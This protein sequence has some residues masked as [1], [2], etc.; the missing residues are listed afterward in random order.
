MFVFLDLEGTIITDWFDALII[1]D[2]VLAEWKQALM[3][4]ESEVTFGIFS[5]AIHDQNDIQYFCAN[6]LPWIERRLGIKIDEENIIP[7]STMRRI[8]LQ[9]NR[10]N[11]TVKEFTQLVTKQTAFEAFVRHS[12][13]EN[14]SWA[15]V[16]DT[17]HDKTIVD[18]SLNTRI[19][20][21]NANSCVWRKI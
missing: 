2:D 21:V 1:R 8:V 12:N 17:V 5:Y 3:A 19:E 15:L 7:V 10:D 9:L 18:H 11:Y 13:K 16:D 4:K 6:M 20:L 14:S